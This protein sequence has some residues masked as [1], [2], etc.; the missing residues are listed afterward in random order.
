MHFRLR[1]HRWKRSGNGREQQ[2]YREGGYII[3]NLDAETIVAD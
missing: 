1:T 3:L 2:R